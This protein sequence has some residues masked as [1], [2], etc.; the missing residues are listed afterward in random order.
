MIRVERRTHDSVLTYYKEKRHTCIRLICSSCHVSIDTDL[1]K[2]RVTRIR[3]AGTR[4][5]QGHAPYMNTE[6]PM[7]AS[8]L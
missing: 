2:L 7:N 3:W 1:T 6:A 8:A 4:D 5:V